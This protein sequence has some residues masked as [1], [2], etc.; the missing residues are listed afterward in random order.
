M[1][2]PGSDIRKITVMDDRIVQQRQSYA[3]EKGGTAVTNQPVLAN[4]Q[5]ASQISFQFQVPSE[6]VFVSRGVNF[7]STYTLTFNCTPPAAV[8]ALIRPG[9]DFALAPFPLQQ[10]VQTTNPV[11]NS[12]SVPVNTGD[13][14]DLLLRLTDYKQVRLQR[15]CPT[16]LS[17]FVSYNTEANTLQNTLAG[18]ENV[19]DRNELPGGAYPIT[20]CNPN[21]GAALVGTGDYSFGGVDVSFINTIPQITNGATAHPVCVQF[22]STEKLLASPFVF[23]DEYQ[24][25]TGLFGIQN[26]TLTLNLQSPARCLRFADVGATGRTCSAPVFTS[27]SGNGGVNNSR[28]DFQV[29]SPSLE[30]PLPP[31]SVVPIYN[32]PRYLTTYATSLAP[33]ATTTIVSQT[34]TLNRIP[35]LLVMAVRPQTYLGT[36]ADWFFGIQRCRIN[37]DNVAGLLSTATQAQLYQSSVHN[38]L[39]MTFPEF[40]GQANFVSSGSSS[41][42]GTTGSILVLKPGIDFAL[43][44]S[45]TA[46]VLGNFTLQFELDILNQS[47]NTYNSG[48]P[49]QLILLTPESGYFESVRGSS[50]VLTGLL[51]PQDVLSSESADVITRMEA[52]R[53]IGG[54]AMGG[55]IMDT[56]ASAISKA[57]SIYDKA[58]PVISAVKEVAKAIPHEKAK[59]ASDVLG[60]LGFGGAKLNERLM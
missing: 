42:V 27:G 9:I 5:S 11:I 4:A 59:K 51:S 19:P 21:T 50:R 26:I 14:K 36:E 45:T 17:S 1:A 56:M 29:I 52:K 38:G 12:T 10:A 47:G 28:L 60:A 40:Q 8:D 44:T 13:V 23:Q 53:V 20:F 49:Y 3:V 2:A 37:F 7:S 54:M 58:K 32:F 43:S 41:I 39:E 22:T 35:D 48:N 55:G 24:W 30:I 16:K 18:Y 25:D 6:Q 57:K 15:T 46:G 33:G 34:I 31:K